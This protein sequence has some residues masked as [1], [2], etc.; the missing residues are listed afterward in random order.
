MCVFLCLW[1]L[2]VHAVYKICMYRQDLKRKKLLFLTWSTQQ[3]IVG[4]I[5]SHYLTVWFRWRCCWNRAGRSRTHG[6]LSLAVNSQDVSASVK[7]SCLCSASYFLLFS[8][9]MCVCLTCSHYVH[10]YLLCTAACWGACVCVFPF[11]WAIINTR[12][13]LIIPC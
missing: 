2:C 5:L 1:P 4:H 13:I 12:R 9:F 8:V 6:A 10:F 7:M 11:L 3:K